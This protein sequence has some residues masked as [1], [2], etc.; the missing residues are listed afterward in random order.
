MPSPTQELT[1]RR[2]ETSDGAKPDIETASSSSAVKLHGGGKGSPARS[3]G[4]KGSDDD[5]SPTTHHSGPFVKS[6]H[7]SRSWVR[8]VALACILS[9]LALLTTLL[10]LKPWKDKHR[11]APV[12]NEAVRSLPVEQP[13]WP[14][15]TS[16]SYGAGNVVLSPDFTI[17]V[18]VGTSDQY[19]GSLI[20][21]PIIDKAI[22]RCMDRLALK[23]NTTRPDV[24]NILS[25]TGT[26]RDNILSELVIS[27]LEPAAA[28]EYGASEMYSLNITF[29]QNAK[30]A[31]VHAHHAEQLSQQSTMVVTG[32]SSALLSTET[33]WGILHGLETFSQLV[34]SKSATTIPP[35]TA[36]SEDA[37]TAT[38]TANIL[39]VPNAP[40]T[41]QDAPQY[42]H[43]GL[44]LDTSRHYFPVV[45]IIRTLDAMS[46]VKLNVFH[47]HVLDQQSYPLVSEKFP[48]LTAKGAERPDRIYSIEDVASIIRF[49]EERGIRVLPEFDAPGH[50]ASWGRAYPNI[51]VCMDALPHS[52]Y[53]AEPPAGQL[54]PLEP[55]TYTVLSGL[56]QEWAA[57]FPDSHVHIGGDEINFNCWKLAQQLK[58]YINSPDLRQDLEAKLPPVPSTGQ[59]TMRKTWSGSQSGEDKLLQVYLDRAIGMYLEQKKIPIVWEEIALEHNVQLPDST[60]VQVWKNAGNAKKI[61]EQ[62]RP[63]ILSSVEYW[64]LDCGSGDWQ[65]GSQGQS[66]CGYTNWQRV[67]AYSLTDKLTSEQQKLVYGGEVCMWAEQ[68]DSSNLDS[69]LW[70]RSAAAAEVLWSGTHDSAGEPR[71]LLQ[72]ARRLSAVRERLVEMGV[73]ASPIFPSWCSK[74]PEACLKE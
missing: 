31:D 14:I 3:Y 46:I 45:D 5:P 54:N 50:T 55:F 70:P 62:G 11:M 60:V 15:P 33:Q 53:A 29:V 61:I 16:F 44:L 9:S 32:I 48:D 36:V 43:R 51:T 40:W 42:S 24:T 13:L 10:I 58:E 65:V 19:L 8:Y 12:D 27:V 52:T 67:Y 57:Q 41:I 72:A 69:N 47:W 7:W 74:H 71:P 2:H 22:A 59:E 35:T 73:R 68:T 21:Y 20:T 56:I 38:Q 17:K 63:V 18:R 6:T 25:S 64:Y 34:Q 23:R 28:L 49:G 4:G 30:E 66:W 39:E 26:S 37:Q 1:R